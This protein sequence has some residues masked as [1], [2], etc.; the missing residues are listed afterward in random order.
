MP[1]FLLALLVVL[2]ILVLFALAA[3]LH[4]QGGS[5]SGQLESGR[6]VSIESDAVSLSCNFEADTA[7]I[8]LGHQEIIVRPEQLIVDGRIVAKISSEAKAVQISVR[9]GEVSFVVDGQRIEQ[10]MN[11]RAD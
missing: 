10:T 11:E 2:P 4:L 7:R 8:V 5:A 1:F 6:T 9:R 3:S